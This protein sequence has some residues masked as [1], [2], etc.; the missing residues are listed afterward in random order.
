MTTQRPEPITIFPFKPRDWISDRSGRIA[1]VKTIYEGR[2]GEILFDIIMYDRDGSCLGRTS[3]VMGGPRTYEPSCSIEGWHRI[4]EPD[5]P[6]SLVWVE[7]G[8][9]R[10]A[11]YYTGDP[12]PPANWKKPARRARR[13]AALIDYPDPYKKALEQIA[14]GHNDARDLA[15][16]VLGRK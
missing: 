6:I 15:E 12:L 11:R 5:F 7:K 8:G 1:R 16:K 3:P 14:D 2:P 9:R 4:P 10:T 13:L